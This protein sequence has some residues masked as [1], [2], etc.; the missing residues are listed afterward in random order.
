MKTE[1]KSIQLNNPFFSI[2][3]PQYNRTSFLIE[4]CKTIASQTFRD[5]EI[6]ISDDCSTDGREEELLNFLKMSSLSF[7]YKK[8][9]NNVRYDA[10]L[11]SAIALASGKFC[12]LLGNDDA[13]ASTIILEELYAT[14]Q[15][16][17]AVGVIITNY[18]DFGTRKKFKRINKTGIIGKGVNTAIA[19]FRNFSFVS[20]IILDNAK[21]KKHSTAKWDGS[22]MYQMFVGCRIVAEGTFLLGI[23]TIT[24]RQGIRIPGEQVDS[25]ASRPRLA[26]CPIKERRIPLNVMGCLVVDALEPYVIPHKRSLIARRIMLQILFFPY[27]FWIFEYRHVQS[28]RYTVGMCLG[29]RPKNILLRLEL[30]SMH[31]LQVLAIYGLI[32]LIGLFTPAYAFDLLYP[33][34][35]KLAKTPHLLRCGKMSNIK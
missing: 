30:T 28:W 27:L 8:Q 10:N 6:C 31:R 14:I 17:K 32:S 9:D 15:R 22:E 7:I 20:G 19:N 1:V 34:L 35:Y 13:L 5:F 24:I 16:F 21:A 4:T 12:F 3:I 18:E 29:M 2:C 33:M 26:W 25:Y 11:R 23:D